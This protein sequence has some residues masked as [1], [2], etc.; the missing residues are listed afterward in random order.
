MDRAARLQFYM[1]IYDFEH[2]QRKALRS[3]VAASIT[4]LLVLSGGLYFY[5]RNIPVLGWK[6]SQIMFVALL[7]LAGVVLFLA[8]CCLARAWWS[9]EAGYLRATS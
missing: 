4:V 6:N 5:I 8:M 9:R 3:D 7:I 1:Q 2:E